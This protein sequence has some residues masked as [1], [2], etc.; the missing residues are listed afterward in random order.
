V[1]ILTGFQVM[2]WELFTFML[3]IHGTHVGLSASTIGIIMG[4][5][6]A[7]TFFIRIILPGIAKR[8]DHWQIF[9]AVI[10]LSAAM[11]VAIPLATTVVPLVVLA[12][13]LGCGLGAA[14]PLAMTLLHEAAPPGRAGEA[15]GIRSA[16]VMGAQTTLPLAFGAFGTAAGMT[17]VFWVVA[18]LLWGGIAVTRT[19]P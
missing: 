10:V 18:L 17:P 4:A 15:V 5:F 8:F 12:F 1:F 3:P 14:Q 13:V 9:K 7:A 6:S 2:S 16:V 19:S 11:F